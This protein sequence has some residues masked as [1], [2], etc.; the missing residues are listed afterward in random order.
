MSDRLP[1]PKLFS[2]KQA[3]EMRS[4]LRNQGKKLVVTNGCFDLLHKGHLYYLRQAKTLGDQ[5]WIVLNAD[6]S[7]R[8]LKGPSRP[9]QPAEDRAYALSALQAVDGIII[10]QGTR[11]TEEILMLEPDT[12]AKAADYTL[13]TLD[14]QE[15]AAL[16]KVGADI[17][18]I[19]FLKGYSTTELI[20][21]IA[22]AV[23]TF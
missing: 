13:E 14:P 10:F 5:L 21:K 6:Q 18:F 20:E 8:E 19:P 11:L 12:Y 1:N 17:Q 2:K 23:D 16:Q 22:R 9:V 4:K 15:R 7:I 3:C